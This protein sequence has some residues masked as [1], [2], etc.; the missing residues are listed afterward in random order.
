MLSG[1]GSGVPLRPGT[2]GGK[3]LK[4]R[5]G[6]GKTQKKQPPYWVT[7]FVC[8]RLPIVP[9]RFQPSIVGT[10]E[11]NFRVRDGNGW[12]LTVINTNYSVRVRR[13]FL[14]SLLATSIYY[15]I[16]FE[17]AS[18]FLKKSEI[19]LLLAGIHVF[20]GRITKR[21]GRFCSQRRPF[22]EENQNKRETGVQQKEGKAVLMHRNRTGAKQPRQAGMHKT[23]PKAESIRLR[24]VLAAGFL[25]ADCRRIFLCGSPAY[26][27]LANNRCGLYPRNYTL[28]R[29]ST[30]SPSC[31]TYSLPSLRT[32]PF[33]R[34]AAMV[35]QAMRSSKA[36]TSARMKPR[37]KSE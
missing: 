27:S 3:R 33:S 7:A 2:G 17:N 36:M 21:G 35:P 20:S 10:S 26:G 16:L 11:L 1:R 23:G 18:L 31:M 37:S 25:C 14:P 28:K 29:N 34:A 5:G 32:S 4:S 8:W 9:G 22:C 24:P 12:T 15:H 19:F 13:D 6:G 30:M